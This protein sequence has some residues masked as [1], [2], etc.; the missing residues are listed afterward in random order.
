MLG[1]VGRVAQLGW[2]DDLGKGRREG[3]RERG[4]E[5]QLCLGNHGCLAQGR[6]EGGR[7]G[8]KTYLSDAPRLHRR[9]RFFQR[10]DH[11][12]LAQD[13]TKVFLVSGIKST[14]LGLAL[15]FERSAIVAEGGRGGREGG[16][17]GGL[18]VDKRP[19]EGIPC[20]WH[21]KHRPLS[22]PAV[23]AEGGRGEREGGIGRVHEP[24]R[25]M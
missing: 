21:R 18:L 15:C 7:G 2:D 19:T 9:Q 10:G 1:V 20:Q 24:S 11:G 16:R 4:E 17:E 6:W 14:A 8:G 12:C 22:C 5:G 25:E 13:K 3:G 23:V